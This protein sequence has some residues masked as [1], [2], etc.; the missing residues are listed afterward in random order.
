MAREVNSK[1]WYPAIYARLSKED[2]DT[3]KKGTSLSID[4]QI[5]MMESFV[6]NQ[7]WQ[8]PK[9]FFDDDRTGTNFNRKGFQDMYAEAQKGNINVIIIKDTSRFGRN[10]V[11]SGEYFEKIDAM[12]IRFISIAE[13]LD[14]IDPKCPALKML[15]F[16]FIFNEWHSQTT[17][18]KIRA[19]FQKQN[20]EGKHRT[21]HAPYGYAKDPSNKYKLIIDIDSAHTVKR[22]F[23]MRLEKWSYRAIAMKLNEDG[24]LSP[25]G[26][27]A[28]KRGVE[29]K[30]SRNNK[31]SLNAIL[32][33]IN[34]PVYC[35]D[36]A[37]GKFSCAG[38]KNQK[39][40]RQP[41]EKWI[42][43]KDMHE[44]I[45]SRE[46]WQ[47]CADMRK[48]LGRVRSTKFR[49][50]SAF[51]GLLKCPDCGYRFN[52]TNVYHMVNGEKQRLIGYN[53]GTYYNKGKTAC[54]THY[55]L[56]RDLKE[57]VLTDI[58]EK[59]SEVLHDEAA[60]RE[61]F[62][63]IKAE[64]NRTQLN[65]DRKA[66]KRINKRLGEL[67][68][69]TQAA[70][71]QSVLGSESSGMFA[72]YAR[73]YEVERQQLTE[74][75]E[76]LEISVEKYSKTENDVET[77]IALMKKYVAV[78]DLDRATAVELIDHITISARTVVPREIVIHYNFIGNT[79]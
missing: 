50:I 37:Q 64:T 13:G 58:R 61:R 26:Y 14:T 32:E 5:S 74:Q 44:P 10:W 41:Q 59:A 62:Y 71:E 67:D 70:F 11:K 16:Y 29:N 79:E 31:W 25:S 76:Q 49:E 57:L 23:A 17:S 1:I 36:I 43:V 9:V 75:A 8:E 69:L 72:E 68:K 42:I 3:K 46:D 28:E 22:I 19:V 55:I 78:S 30:K 6:Q 73:K 48:N 39:Q 47:K 15:P 77:F 21:V 45:V 38:Y 34:N 66:L 51:S 18:E 33:I 4:H 40:I 27:S 20:Q 53:C 12:G 24:I 7:G 60:A 35:G 52:R 2:E 56:E 65:A 63:A 54:T